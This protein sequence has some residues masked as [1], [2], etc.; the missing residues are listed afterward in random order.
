MSQGN[1]KVFMAVMSLIS[2][3]RADVL[4]AGELVLAGEADRFASFRSQI[5]RLFGRTRGA[6][7]KLRDLFQVEQS[8]NGQAGNSEFCG[9]G[10]AS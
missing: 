10:D 3:L 9:K 4:Q 6:E 1:S 2:G 7:K 8:Q 5:L